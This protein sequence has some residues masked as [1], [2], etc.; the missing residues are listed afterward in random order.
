RALLLQPDLI[1]ADEPVSA[2]DVSI[3]AQI[4]NLMKRLQNDF[5]L[6]YIFISHDLSVVRYICDRVAVM[7]LGKMMELADKETLFNEPLHPYTQALMSAVPVLKK[8]G[9]VSRERIVLE[10]DM[11][12]PSNPPKGCVFHTRCPAAMD[13]CKEKA[14]QFKEIKEDHFIACHLY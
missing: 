10:G 6:T 3:Q 8:K 14:P 12:S 5:N 11:P 4:I 13:I 9:T 2:L 1:I 7:Y